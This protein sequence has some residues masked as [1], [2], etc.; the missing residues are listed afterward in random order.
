MRRR[1][2]SS[3][4]I[5][6]IRISSRINLFVGCRVE[7]VQLEANMNAT[8]KAILIWT[9]ILVTAVALWNIVEKQK[10]SATAL[11]LT[12]FLEAVDSKRVAE[13]TIEGSRLT[14]R[15]HPDNQV[16]RS[17]IPENYAGLYERLMDS[18]IKVNIV[19]VERRSWLPL[20]TFWLLTMFVAFGL[21][22]LCALWYQGRGLQPPMTL[23]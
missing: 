15:L 3:R 19:P 13:V 10:Q 21:G 2:N 17:A 12:E 8:V 6:T 9:L 1:A 20:L 5:S 16:F 22:W 4:S 14:G 23:A 18:G 7:G 11:S